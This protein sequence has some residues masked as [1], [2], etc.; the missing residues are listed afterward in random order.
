VALARSND[1]GLFTASLPVLSVWP[2]MAIAVTGLA[3]SVPAN[4]LSTPCSVGLTVER[5]VAKPASAGTSSFRRLSAVCVT[6]MPVPAV[7]A[8]MAFF[9]SCILVDQM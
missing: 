9:C 4:W 8:S 5:P 6:P 3:L 7:A 1:S 2:T